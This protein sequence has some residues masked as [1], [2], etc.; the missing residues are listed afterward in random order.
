MRID[1]LNR[2]CLICGKEFGPRIEECC[3]TDSLV[4]ILREGFLRRRT[5]YFTLDGHEL[6]EKGLS[7][8]R[9]KANASRASG[10]RTVGQTAA[11]SSRSALLGVADP[12]KRAQLAAAMARSGS[13]EDGLYIL[14]DGLSKHPLEFRYAGLLSELDREGIRDDR[15]IR[16]IISFADRFSFDDVRALGIGSGNPLNAA[17]E[18]ALKI[19]ERHKEEWHAVYATVHTPPVRTLPSDIAIFDPGSSVK[20]GF[21]PIEEASAITGISVEEIR[22]LIRE[23]QV[24]S[25]TSFRGDTTVL[26]DGYYPCGEVNAHPAHRNRGIGAEPDA[27]TIAS[28]SDSDLNLKRYSKSGK[29]GV[30]VRA[31]SGGWNHTDWL[32]LLE[33]IRQKGYWPIDEQGLGELLERLK[34]QFGTRD[35]IPASSNR[36][37]TAGGG[38]VDSVHSDQAKEL[39]C[40]HC[41]KP[42]SAERWPLRGDFVPYIYERERSRFSLPVNCPHCKKLWYVVWDTEPGPI[43]KAV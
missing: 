43:V 28:L 41:A 36:E 18:Y 35:A 11:S 38:T 7:K 34:Q 33:G 26:L 22:R 2:Q 24:F 9:E 19:K 13:K 10:S 14:Y 4:A 6:D 8:A 15:L 16:E 25:T 42:N 21:F 39:Y 17:L 32:Q 23:R 3:T 40:P 30:W 5:H 1:S 31:N 37:G 20:I 29:A 27:G 12:S